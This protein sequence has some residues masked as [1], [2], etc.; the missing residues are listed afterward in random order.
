[1]TAMSA[2][3]ASV[4]SA[5]PFPTTAP[6][7][8]PG[9]DRTYEVRDVLRGMGL[10]WDPVSHAWHGTLPLDQGSRLAREYGLK[11]Q[12]VPMIEAF[13]PPEA[14]AP[15]IPGPRPPT[16]PPT[17]PRPHV[18]DYSRTRLE[19]RVAVGGPDEDA[20]EIATATWRFSLLEITSALPDDSREADDRA[21]ARRLRGAGARV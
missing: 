16:R 20:E 10:R 3:R 6:V 11:P 19:S 1:M 17:P 7:R 12:V 21:A 15:R 14:R 5:N 18:G 13:A 2:Q 4:D 8:I 9:S